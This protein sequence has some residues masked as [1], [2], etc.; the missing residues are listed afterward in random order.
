MSGVFF[1]FKP[2]PLPV[3][4][5]KFSWIYLNCFPT[6]STCYCNVD[7]HDMGACGYLFLKFTMSLLCLTSCASHK[8]ALMCLSLQHWY[9]EGL[10]QGYYSFVCFLKKIHIVLCDCWDLPFWIFHLIVQY[11]ISI[12]AHG[13]THVLHKP[14]SS[15]ALLNS[16]MHYCHLV[17]IK[18]W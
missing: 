15:E 16:L 13:A 1:A 6:A 11:L 3:R 17:L 18:K 2:E 9:L 5:S 4:G 12:Y 14:G 8:V 7:K 10:H